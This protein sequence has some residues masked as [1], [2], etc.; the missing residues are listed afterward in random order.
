MGTIT[1]QEYV[2]TMPDHF[3]PERARGVKAVIQFKLSGEGG[4]DWYLTVKDGTSTVTEGVSDAAQA[5][6]MMSAS[7]YIA[8]ATGKLGGMKAFLSGKVKTSGDFSLL[9]RME[10]WFPR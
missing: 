6:I 8:L 5:T 3:R 7:D 1:A 9:K 2:E 4:G 10:N